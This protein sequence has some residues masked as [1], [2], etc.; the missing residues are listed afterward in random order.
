MNSSNNLFLHHDVRKG[1]IPS[2][3]SSFVNLIES[4]V[5]VEEVELSISMQPDH[6]GV[7]VHV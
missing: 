2:I 5:V 6:K 7:M 3:S 1:L 4:Y